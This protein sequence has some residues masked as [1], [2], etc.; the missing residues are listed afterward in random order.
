MNI[1]GRPG[2]Q[3]QHEFQ[4]LYPQ[5]R[6]PGTLPPIMNKFSPGSK[7]SGKDGKKHLEKVQK[8]TKDAQKMTKDDKKDQIG[9]SIMDSN[10]DMSLLPSIPIQTVK[11]LVMGTEKAAK[12]SQQTLN[13]KSQLSNALAASTTSATNSTKRLVLGSKA[14][15]KITISDAGRAEVNDDKKQ[16]KIETTRS[17]TPPTTPT[18][19]KT[20]SPKKIAAT[21]AHTPPAPVDVSIVAPSTPAAVNDPSQL[22]KLAPISEV[23]PVAPSDTD[24][25]V[26]NQ[27]KKRKFHTDLLELENNYQFKAYNGDLLSNKSFEVNSTASVKDVIQN[28]QIGRNT[29]NVLAPVNLITTVSP[30]E[31]LPMLIQPRQFQQEFIKYTQTDDKSQSLSQQLSQSVN[32][33][34]GSHNLIEISQPYKRQRLSADLSSIPSSQLSQLPQSNSQNVQIGHNIGQNMSVSLMKLPSTI[35]PQSQFDESFSDKGINGGYPQPQPQQYTLPPHLLQQTSQQPPQL[36]YHNISRSY[37]QPL[38]KSQQ[39]Q[40]SIKAVNELQA[41]ISHFSHSHIFAQS[42]L[43]HQ[44]LSQQQQQ[45]QFQRQRQ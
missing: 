17:I 29:T 36:Y 24:Q 33:T 19:T 14:R 30:P 4:R 16:E 11:E 3:L 39:P 10:I 44:L 22:V 34:I 5:R 28:E 27:N 43:T 6:V 13:L 15:P 1:P 40:R 41:R 18:S 32:S 45:Y 35:I 25:H 37:L 8:D 26:F 2:V 42:V 12:M 20:L 38:P 31:P 9:D 7:V 23:I 21:V